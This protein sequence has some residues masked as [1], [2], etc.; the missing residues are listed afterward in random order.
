[1]L[2]SVYIY[3]S[4]RKNKTGTVFWNTLYG[5][6]ALT[7]LMFASQFEGTP[8]TACCRLEQVMSY[9][10]KSSVVQVQYNVTLIELTFTTRMIILKA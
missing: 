2:K 5:R 6:N 1:M 4:Y 10:I 9:Y 8:Y 7:E 3:G